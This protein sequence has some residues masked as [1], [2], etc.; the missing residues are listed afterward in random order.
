[1]LYLVTVERKTYSTL[2]FWTI[3]SDQEEALANLYDDLIGF[4]EQSDEHDG[5]VVSIQNP[6]ISRG[7][8]TE[9]IEGL[10]R[11]ETVRLALTVHRREA[12]DGPS[13]R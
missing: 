11:A 12:S 6:V 5:L 8:V 2:R 13:P 7:S 10:T 4:F 3:A 1:M 9:S